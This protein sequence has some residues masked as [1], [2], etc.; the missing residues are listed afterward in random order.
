MRYMEKLP[1]NNLLLLAD[2]YSDTKKY[3][4]EHWILEYAEIILYKIK[5][6]HTYT[7]HMINS[8]L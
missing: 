6:T 7:C 5:I 8:V 2:R 1:N 3:V 4:P